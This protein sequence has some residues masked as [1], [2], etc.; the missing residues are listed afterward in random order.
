MAKSEA[1][2]I[3]DLLMGAI[4]TQVALCRFLIR[5]NT[6]QKRELLAYLDERGQTWGKTASVVA[7]LPLVTLKA[8]LESAQ[9]PNFPTTLH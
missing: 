6:V 3:L 2:Q 1:D 8:A 7:L 5:E 4:M 9:E